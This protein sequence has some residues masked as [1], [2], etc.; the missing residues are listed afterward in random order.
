[1]GAAVGLAVAETPLSEKATS[2]LMRAG[3]FIE[4][5]QA[6]TRKGTSPP[7]PN[8]GLWRQRRALR[9]KWMRQENG[10]KKSPLIMPTIG[11][12]SLAGFNGLPVALPGAT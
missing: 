11:N 8:Y 7:S 9:A 3:A 1:M 4:L 12:E 10:A 6:A 2:A 5:L